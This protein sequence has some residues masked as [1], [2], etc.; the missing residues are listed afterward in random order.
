MKKLGAGQNIN[1]NNVLIVGAVF[2]TYFFILKPILE[3]LG[4]KDTEEEKARK[5]QEE[6]AIKDAEK[7]TTTEYN[8]WSNLLYKDAVSGKVGK[9]KAIYYKNTTS[10]KKLA[11]SIY[12]SI[13]RSWYSSDNP[14]SIESAIKQC[15][16]KVQISQLVNQY[17]LQYSLDL[18][19][20]I[21]NVLYT[22]ETG[23]ALTWDSAK[24][25]DTFNRILIYVESLPLYTY[26]K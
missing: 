11:D 21:K 16:S 19:A 26:K 5:K 20:D 2:S 3:G 4:L 17:Y 25:R 8:P 1:F 13:G 23:R 7:F 22:E 9:G 14:E 10:I 24:Q 18:Y 12:N 15:T 6:N